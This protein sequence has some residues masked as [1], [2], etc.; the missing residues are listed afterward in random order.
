M[1]SLIVETPYS[2]ITATL[3]VLDHFGVGRDDLR[4]FRAASPD[5]QRHMANM[6]RDANALTSIETVTERASLLS[7]VATINLGAVKGKKTAKCFTSGWYY[8]DGDF[9]RFLGTDQPDA[10]ACAVSICAVNSDWT[11]VEAVRALAGAPQTG[12]TVELGNWAIKSGY[13]L[14]LPQIEDIVVRTERGEN[15]GLRT[16]G[17]VNCFLVGTGDPENPVSVG[18]VRR[19]RRGW[20]AFVYRLGDGLRWFAGRRLLVR[21]LD[22]S[23]F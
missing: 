11:F 22:A 16:D 9:D 15:T 14:A 7:V 1:G 10:D 21:N 4:K 3:E 5:V 17:G 23:K 6:F 18:L 20:L 8:R 13:T 19:V 12:D 2:E